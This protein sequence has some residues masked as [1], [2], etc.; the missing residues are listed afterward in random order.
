MYPELQITNVV[1]AIETIR[2]E[3]WCKK[4]R[5]VCKGYTHFVAPYKCLGKMATVV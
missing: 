2:I 1:E 3:N 4:E 5:K